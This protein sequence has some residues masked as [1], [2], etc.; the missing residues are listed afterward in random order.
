MEPL[1][2]ILRALADPSRVRILL[3]VRRMELSVGE[4][5]AVL[6]QSQPRVSRHIRILSDAGLVKR[7]KEGAWVFVRLGEAGVAGPVLAA[8]DALA[9]DAGIVDQARLAAVREERAAAADA[10]FATHAASWDRERS[11]YIAESAVEA[12][13]IAALGSDALGNLVDVGTGTG[14]MIEL[15]GPR[16]TTAL[17]ID[18]SPEMLRLA[19]GRIEGAGLAHA[20]VR[21][22]DMYAL[23]SDDGSVDTVVLHQVLHFADDPAAVIAEAAR[24]LAPAGRLLIVDFMPHNREELRNQQRHLRLGFADAQMI[25]WM[26]AAG[27]AGAVVARLPDREAIGVT[28][29]LGTREARQTDE[30]KAA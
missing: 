22:G 26:A 2:I 30:R 10:W 5:A 24:V 21:R 18:R 9:A 11:L 3:L 28:L 20:E 4:I 25:D 6:E 29:W 16:A 7:S 14:R 19:R 17:G 23:P 1:L 27:L 13:V 12:A 15:L 8:M